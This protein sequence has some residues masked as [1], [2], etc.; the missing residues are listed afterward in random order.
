LIPLLLIRKSPT[1]KKRSQT[2]STFDDK[3]T[4]QCGFNVRFER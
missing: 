2:V 4:Y 1:A 3:L